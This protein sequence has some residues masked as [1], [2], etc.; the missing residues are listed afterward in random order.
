VLVLILGELR[1]LGR[2]SASSWLLRVLGRSSASMVASAVEAVLPARLVVLGELP[3]WPAWS[4][5]AAQRGRGWSS[6][7]RSSC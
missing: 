3:M 4:C 5:S 2:S 7:A 6:A 1:V